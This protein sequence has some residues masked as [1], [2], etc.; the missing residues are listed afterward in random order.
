MVYTVADEPAEFPGGT[1]A[2]KMY[3]AENVIYPQT[4][5]EN[6][7]QGKCFLQFV[8]T[9][10]GEITD[11]KVNK[12]VLNCSERDAESIRMVKS[13]PKWGPGKVNGK[14]VNSI[15]NLPVSFK[16]S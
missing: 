1:S 6:G 10:K 9:E 14:A 5:V 15:I 7:L 3:L 13:M 4:A 12:G 11:I 8:V 2:L 16:L